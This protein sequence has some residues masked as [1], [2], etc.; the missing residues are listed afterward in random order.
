[1]EGSEGE[2]L[3]CFHVLVIPD[4][5]RNSGARSGIQG[6]KVLDYAA[7]AVI[8]AFVEPGNPG[9]WGQAPG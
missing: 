6:Y 5:R 8:A 4:K 3:A 9:S 2:L 7:N 1:M